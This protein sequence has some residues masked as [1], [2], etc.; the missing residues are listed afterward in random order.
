MAL[1]VFAYLGCHHFFKA[2]GLEQRSPLHTADQGDAPCR[3]DL[4]EQVKTAQ[5]LS[6]NVLITVCL[7][8]MQNSKEA[9]VL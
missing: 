1:E 7:L 4:V 3:M 2:G 8:G 5:G 6:Q 9:R